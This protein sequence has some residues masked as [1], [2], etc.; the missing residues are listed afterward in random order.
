MAFDAQ[1]VAQYLGVV[2]VS[3]LYQIIATSMYNPGH[4]SIKYTTT[5]CNVSHAMWHNILRFTMVFTLAGILMASVLFFG[6]F[7]P[8]YIKYTYSV[9][10]LHMACVLFSWML[11]LFPVVIHNQQ[12]APVR[13]PGD[14]IDSASV[15]DS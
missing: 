10:L 13:G 3:I 8:A 12:C 14:F 4:R 11:G 7:P 15:A 2:I 5:I 1:H 9:I 6:G